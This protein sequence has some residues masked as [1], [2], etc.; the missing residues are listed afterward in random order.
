M[1]QRP[2]SPHLQVYRLPPTAVTSITHRATGV[3]LS[4]GMVFLTVC[5]TAISENEARFL[6]IRHLLQAA[7]GRV[8][9]WG[10][11]FSLYFHLCHGIR[12]LGWDVG[13]GFEQASLNRH[14]YME[15]A[16][17]VILTAATLVLT[18]LLF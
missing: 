14:A 12:H 5:L 17:S 13:F 2:L 6:E 3:F 16:A 8:F 1:N 18:L 9:I 11:I 7:P 10:L 15:I 4:L